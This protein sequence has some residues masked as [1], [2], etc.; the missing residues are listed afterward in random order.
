M[1]PA[2][3]AGPRVF[4][5]VTAGSG[6]PAAA[7]AGLLWGAVGH[8]NNIGAGLNGAYLAKGS[9]TASDPQPLQRA[10]LLNRL[11]VLDVD[12]TAIDMTVGAYESVDDW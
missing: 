4:W 1:P 2:H 9:W 8:G 5:V 6:A 7:C 3:P 11:M 10:Q 12:W